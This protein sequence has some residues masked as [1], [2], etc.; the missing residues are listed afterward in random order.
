MTAGGAVSSVLDRGNK[1]FLCSKYVKKED[2]YFPHA[3]AAAVLL[4][5]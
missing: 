5:T 3:A 4:H 1:R 2:T